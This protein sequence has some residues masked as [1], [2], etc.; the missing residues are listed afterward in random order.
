MIPLALA[1]AGLLVSP[2]LAT[3]AILRRE[4]VLSRPYA[5]VAA[6]T[7]LTRRQDDGSDSEDEQTT[8]NPDG[9]LNMTSFSAATD[10]ACRAALSEMARASSPSGM[11]ICFNLPSLNTSDGVF[12]ADLRLYRVSEPRDAWVAVNTSEID[13]NVMFQNAR[14]GSVTEESVSGVGQVGELA[15]RDVEGKPELAARQDGGQQ[16]QQADLPVLMQSYMLVGQIN[17]SKMSDN[18]T[19]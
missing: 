7:T 13:V 3:K 16:Q 5:S 19:M 2:A 10:E 6:D 15:A 17:Q 18:M 4:D 8:L 14:V 12:E 11:S 1:L 9:T